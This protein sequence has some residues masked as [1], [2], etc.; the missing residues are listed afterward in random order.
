MDKKEAQLL[1][2]MHAD[3]KW[4]KRSLEKKANKWTERVLITFMIGTGA[5]VGNQLLNLIPKVQ[6]LF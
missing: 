5:W 1:G 2:E 3:I 6:A 4:I